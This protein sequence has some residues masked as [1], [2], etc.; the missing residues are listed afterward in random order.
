MTVDYLF[1]PY[2][3]DGCELC[4]LSRRQSDQE[5][6]DRCWSDNLSR[7]QR[8]HAIGVCVEII[9]QIQAT[10]RPGEG[11]K[12]WKENWSRRPT[13]LVHVGMIKQRD[14]ATRRSGYMWSS[15]FLIYPWQE[16]MP[17]NPNYFYGFLEYNC[18]II[19]DG[20]LE[21]DHLES[22]DISKIAAQRCSGFINTTSATCGLIN[23][24]RDEFL[25]SLE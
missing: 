8:D 25:F 21:Y 11:D 18:F 1:P 2:T 9:I 17:Y 16:I 5:M 24:K 7:L 20:S 13:R 10:T 15:E 6:R 12:C 3:R 14:N 22:I 23:A 19:F 4:Q